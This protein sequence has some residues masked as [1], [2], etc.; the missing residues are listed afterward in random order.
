MSK[1][2]KMYIDLIKQGIEV[3]LKNRIVW[4]KGES[5]PRII[6]TSADNLFYIRDGSGGKL[7][8][9]KL[10]RLAKNVKEK[11]KK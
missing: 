4:V 5:A 8:L 6:R 3:D 9:G 7:Y 1:K 11:V 2:E 10:K